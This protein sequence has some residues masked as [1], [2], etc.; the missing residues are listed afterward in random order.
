MTMEDGKGSEVFLYLAGGLAEASRDHFQYPYPPVLRH[1]LNVLSATMIRQGDALP[2][3]MPD[4]LWLFEQ[5]VGEWWP[6]TLPEG[7]EPE[8]TL[9]YDATVDDWVWELLETHDLTA[10]SGKSLLNFQAAIDQVAVRE[11]RDF[12]RGNLEF[13]EPVYVDV[14]CFLVR[15]PHATLAQLHH[16]TSRL[17]IPSRLV[18]DLY[19][20]REAFENHAWF[21][22]CFW[23]CPHC[24]GILNWFEGRPRCAR[25]SVC[26]RLY[27]G[28]QGREPI[29]DDYPLRLKWRHHVRTC[30]PGIPEVDL[31]DELKKIA[32]KNPLLEEVK[33]WPGVDRYDLYLRFSNKE[34]WAVDVKDYTSS[35]TLAKRVKGQQLY[36]RGDLSWQRGF[37][38][39]PDYRLDWNRHYVEQF[40]GAAE[41]PEDMEAAGIEGFI[42]LVEKK[43]QEIS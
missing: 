27:P 18:M 40:A 41:L 28:Y 3:A 42:T 1:A 6:G 12:C 19:E 14:R 17:P 23:K 29:E 10:S 13:L 7:I 37:Y 15:H 9:L 21:D 30:I 5:P 36:R 2:P 22:G 38:V 25:H 33:L 31:A 8:F 32:R 24:R 20:T 11:L 26:G 35:I 34:V 39:F 43:L 16:L 4:I